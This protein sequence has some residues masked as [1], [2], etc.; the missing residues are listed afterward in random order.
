M[1]ESK[2]PPLNSLRAFEAAGRLRSFSRAALE[3]N[4][5]SGAISRH[6]QQ[7]EAWLGSPLFIRRHRR[8]ELTEEGAAYLHEA[9]AA[10]GRLALATSR[11][12]RTPTHK[13]LR[14]NSATS[15]TLRWLIP[16]L[17]RFQRLHPDIEVRIQASN[18]PLEKISTPYDIAIRFGRQAG[19][20]SRAV[21]LLSGGNMPF[22]SPKLLAEKPIRDVG[23]LARHTLLHVPLYATGW[24]RW[25]AEAGAPDLEPLRSVT[26]DDAY[27]AI[28]AA[29]DGLGI[30]MAPAAFVT[31]DVAEG[32]LVA[33]FDSLVLP[34]GGMTGDPSALSAEERRALGYHAYVA[35]G[36]YDEAAIV[37]FLDWL[38]ATGEGRSPQ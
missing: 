31:D 13:V 29:I 10:L 38:R 26:F 17:S 11:I 5:S 12:R 30:A 19:E 18:E 9:S 7:L 32:R 34:M 23:D 6:I 1:T 14:V 20:A 15:F 25:L 28:Q 27:M 2:L 21:I 37:Q 33:P 22:C 35:E 16:K 24:P 4:V 8:V 36:R 3:L